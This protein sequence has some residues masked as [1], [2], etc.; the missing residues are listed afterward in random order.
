MEAILHTRPQGYLAM[1][2]DTWG[3]HW[4]AK[5]EVGENVQHAI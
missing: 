2:G 3:C 1:S 5:E 4:G